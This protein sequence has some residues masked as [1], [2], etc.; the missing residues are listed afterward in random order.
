M[1]LVSVVGLA[2]VGIAFWVAYKTRPTL[3]V[4]RNYHK[5]PPETVEDSGVYVYPTYGI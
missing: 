4:K 2:V 5:A 3:S 1:R